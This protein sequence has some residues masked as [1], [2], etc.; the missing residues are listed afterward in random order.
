MS[1][2]PPKEPPR[3]VEQKIRELVLHW[4][5]DVTAIYQLTVTGLKLVRV[6]KDVREG[7]QDKAGSSDFLE[8]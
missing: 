3:R 5:P 6:F 2:L 7:T 4:P 8:R 1:Q